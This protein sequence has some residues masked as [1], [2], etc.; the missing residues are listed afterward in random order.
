[1]QV[2]AGSLTGQFGRRPR[3][4]AERMLDE[5]CCHIL[6]TDAHGTDRRVP[7][8][9][10][11]RDLAARRLGD[12]SSPPGDKSPGRRPPL[13]QTRLANPKHRR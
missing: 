2:T 4:W 1:M 7:R 12:L 5:G 9:S 8:L 11:A 10:E 6:A 3:Y 13:A